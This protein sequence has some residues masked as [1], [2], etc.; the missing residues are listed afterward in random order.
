MELK[1]VNNNPY[2]YYLLLIN[3][4]FEYFEVILLIL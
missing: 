3:Q 1:Q 4:T 2:H